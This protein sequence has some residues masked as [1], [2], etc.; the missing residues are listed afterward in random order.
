MLRGMFGETLTTELRVNN[1][2]LTDEIKRD[3]RDEMHSI[4]K[5][6]ESVLRREIHQM[7]DDI[8]DVINEGILPQID[9]HDREIRGIK[10]HLKFA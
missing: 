3:I 4:V 6:S 8:L 10:H 2:I 7:R 5:A 9:E 1:Q